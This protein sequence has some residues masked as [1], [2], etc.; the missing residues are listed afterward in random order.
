MCGPEHK[1]SLRI[2]VQELKKLALSLEIFKII[3]S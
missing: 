1:V 3:D 2:E